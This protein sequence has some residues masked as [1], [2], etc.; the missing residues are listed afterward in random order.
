MASE[1]AIYYTPMYFMWGVQSVATPELILFDFYMIAIWHRIYK[2][3]MI[4]K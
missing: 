1:L 4:I 2:Y 3:I